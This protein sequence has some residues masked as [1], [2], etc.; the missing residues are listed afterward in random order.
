MGSP[1]APELSST[2]KR[3]ATDFKHA[4]AAGHQGTEARWVP[5]IDLLSGG[6]SLTAVVL[7]ATALG[8]PNRQELDD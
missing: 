1:I 4:R 8:D 3:Q 7:A 6:G 2:G 5:N